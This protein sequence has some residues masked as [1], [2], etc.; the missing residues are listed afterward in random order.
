MQTGQRWRSRRLSALGAC[1]VAVVVSVS[2]SLGSPA[3]AQLPARTSAAGAG[4]SCANPEVAS[5][6]L[7]PTLSNLSLT[8]GSHI[9]L[10][11]FF[12]G[13]PTTTEWLVPAGYFI[14]GTR[15][16]L[17]NGSVAQP[18]YSFPSGTPT[19]IG[20]QYDEAADDPGSALS[21]ITVMA[22]KSPVPPGSSCRYPQE[23]S[24]IGTVSHGGPKSRVSV[25]VVEASPTRLRLKL[26]PHK[27]NLTLCPT[28]YIMLWL[29]GPGG[30]LVRRLVFPVSV[31][32]HGGLS[33][34]VTV[35]AGSY[36]PKE[37][38]PQI[39]AQAFARVATA[40]Q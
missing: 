27:A 3:S 13:G 19:A 36:T 9:E 4:S 32:P 1:V 28:A 18:T 22:A 23:S 30:Y 8:P 6:A 15:L 14:C 26:K 24:L 33:S 39:E 37:G 21:I 11:P 5:W 40:K 10:I 2:P 25:N 31:K 12:G 35:P 16:Q 29:P 7:L 20:G 38:P 34:T 17:A